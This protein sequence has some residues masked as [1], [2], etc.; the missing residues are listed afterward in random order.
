[1]NCRK[2]FFLNSYFWRQPLLQTCL[3]GEK[4]TLDNVTHWHII[5]KKKTPI[6]SMVFYNVWNF[7]FFLG[8]GGSWLYAYQLSLL[9][10]TFEKT[11]L[12]GEP[13]RQR[14][15]VFQD[16]CFS[17]RNKALVKIYSHSY[18][19]AVYRRK[20]RIWVHK[21]EWIIDDILGSLQTQLHSKTMEDRCS[22]PP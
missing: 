9:T 14:F 22:I 17:S 3:R 18:V 11:H 16:F 4:I 8:G 7:H 20:P 13:F 1:M 12:D 5:F 19:T 2:N 15:A 10:V 21:R 6:Y